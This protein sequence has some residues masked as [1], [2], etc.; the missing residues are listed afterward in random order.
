[1]GDLFSGVASAYAQFRPG[2]PQEI[3]GFLKRLLPPGTLV[4]EAGCGSGQ[5]TRVLAPAFP[6]VV[7]SDA[8]AAQVARAPRLTGVTYLV[9]R[10]ESSALAA[11]IVGLAV[12]AQS[13]HWFELPG[14]YAEARRVSAAGAHVVLITYGRVTGP[15]GLD[16]LLENLFRALSAFWPEERRYVDLGYRTLP[17]PF[18]EVEAP[19]LETSERWTGREFLGYVRTWSATQALI[20]Q[21]GERAFGRLREEILS[22]WSAYGSAVPLRW[23]VRMRAGRCL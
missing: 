16:P 3:T 5:F 4:W 10:A 1:M 21:Q 6:G 17:F 12:A 15:P 2:Y 20:A 19:E 14:Y 9:E 23:P 8:S 11:G 22:A 18:P 7:A 13:A